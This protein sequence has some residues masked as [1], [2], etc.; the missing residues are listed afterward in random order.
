MGDSAITEDWLR[1]VGF[2]YH[3]LDR[4]PNRHWLLWCGGQPGSLQS[5][6][7]LGVE[8]ML[9]HDHEK[10]PFFY[11]WLRGDY[12][13]RYSRFIHIRHMSMQAELIRLVEA[14]TG[15]DWNPENHW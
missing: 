1:D 5:F 4:A 3:T 9:D 8:V 12:S 2:R 6:E 11:C 15:Q 13:G 10:R 14:I 7:D